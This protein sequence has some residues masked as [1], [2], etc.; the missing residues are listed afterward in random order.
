[1]K[2][3]LIH[4]GYPKSA[5]SS[6]QHYF[7]ELKEKN[8]K[9]FD[10]NKNIKH[11]N[12]LK[13]ILQLNNKKYKSI[14]HSLLKYYK[15]KSSK[16]NIISSE[17]FTYPYGYLHFD[18]YQR[19]SRVYY[20]FKKLKFDVYFLVV[21]R[22]PK[23]LLIS[24]YTDMLHR[25]V[26]HTGKMVTFK[27][28]LMLRNKNKVVKYIFK[29]F[30]FNKTI[31]YL[32]SNLKVNKKNINVLICENLSS[33]Q[34][35]A[36]LNK[37][38]FKINSKKNLK[39]LNKSKKNKENYIRTLDPTLFLMATDPKYKILKYSVQKILKKNNV[40]KKMLSFVKF[41]NKLTL[42]TKGLINNYYKKDLIEIDK[43]YKLNLFKYKYF[44]LT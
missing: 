1:M 13:N 30:N 31:K 7:S 23:K 43:N 42:N 8:I 2:K 5:S 24:F 26:Q 11:K 22:D 9:Y 28:F 14:E 15:T 20:L 19:I 6:L 10:I 21:I 4:I 27:E 17:H 25:I 34:L 16:Y 35:K 33:K 32:N 29:I 3:V 41:E 40:F 12:N 39:Y 36:K 37:I 18:N 38:D 44:D